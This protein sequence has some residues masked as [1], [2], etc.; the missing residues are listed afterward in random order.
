MTQPHTGVDPWLAGVDVEVRDGVGTGGATAAGTGFS[1]SPGEANAILAK[2]TS[3]FD[4]L[5]ELQRK[6]EILKQVS[7]AADDPASIAYNDRLASGHGVFDAADKHINAEAAYL[8]ELIRKIRLALRL[9]G[10]SDREAAREL[11][12][13]GASSGGVAG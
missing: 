8:E 11:G 5:Q 12:A 2:A 7:P 6:A 13:R 4:K 1:L 3:A 9:T 10:Q